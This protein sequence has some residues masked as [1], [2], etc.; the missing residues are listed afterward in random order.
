MSTTA[1][2]PS[3]ANSPNIS[4]VIPCSLSPRRGSVSSSPPTS[5][6][7]STPP[8]MATTVGSEPEYI[9]TDAPSQWGVSRLVRFDNECVAIPESEWFA[10]S[11]DPNADGGSTSKAG[12]K[13]GF[14][15][16]KMKKVVMVNKSY[17]L[18]FG[19]PEARALRRKTTS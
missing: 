1:N 4:Y 5:P 14:G 16:N 18:P 2:T 8:T 11:D 3:Q 12:L 6:L 7:P 19:P 9:T 15:L 10:H 17:S 13:S